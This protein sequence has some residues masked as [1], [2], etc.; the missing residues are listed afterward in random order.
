MNNKY[1]SIILVASA[2]ILFLIFK[3]LILVVAEVLVNV[4]TSLIEEYAV[5]IVVLGFP[6]LFYAYKSEAR[7]N[8]ELQ[9][10]IDDHVTRWENLS[11]KEN[12][13]TTK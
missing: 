5:P 8:I 11:A 7:K 13:N 3:D 12:L 9:K 2:V 10:R 4:V 6:V 1:K